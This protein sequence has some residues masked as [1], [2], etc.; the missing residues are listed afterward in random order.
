M[1]DERI[2]VET[3]DMVNRTGK[4][5]AVAFLLNISKKTLQEWRRKYGNRRK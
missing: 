3:V 4:H 2:K 1:I 5:M